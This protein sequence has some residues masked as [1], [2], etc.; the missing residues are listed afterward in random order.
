ML[1]RELIQEE[2]ISTIVGQPERYEAGKELDLFV[3]HVMVLLSSGNARSRL[4]DRR[5]SS[6]TLYDF[7]WSRLAC[8]GL[9]D[10]DLPIYGFP[11]PSSL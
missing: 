3:S 5:G 6:D 4:G 9:P 7:V 8:A 1:S 11:S 10:D 2:R